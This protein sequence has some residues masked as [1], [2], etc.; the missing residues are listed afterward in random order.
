MGIHMLAMLQ[1]S[2]NS[3]PLIIC[4]IL[5]KSSTCFFFISMGD[6]CGDE[7]SQQPPLATIF[8]HFGILA[9]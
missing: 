8:W 9:F 6:R 3:G 2:T 7:K 4:N 5:K 1:K